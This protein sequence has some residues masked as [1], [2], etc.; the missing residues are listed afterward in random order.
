MIK[1]VIIVEGKDDERVIK[2]SVDAEVIT[3]SGWGLN[4]R[5]IKRIIEANKRCG[6]IIFTDPDFAGEKIRERL[7]KMLDNPKHAFLSKEEATKNDNIGIEN[8]SKESVINA[9]KKVRPEKRDY[10]KTFTNE[11]M[12]ENGLTGNN[13][14]AINRNE[15]GKILGIGYG[16]SKQFLKRLNKYGVT[17]RE[18]ENAINEYNAI[19]NNTN[20]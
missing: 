10:D 7:S 14:A 16:N 6:I 12:F 9:L 8:A 18:F 5:I 15:I 17:R 13:N 3:T 20:I 11:D 1:E 2:N 4:D 19:A